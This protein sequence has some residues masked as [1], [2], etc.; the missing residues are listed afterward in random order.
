MKRFPPAEMSVALE[1]NQQKLDVIKHHII[2]SE[3]GNLPRPNIRRRW[4]ITYPELFCQTYD[5]ALCFGQKS[6]S[7]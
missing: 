2:I 1:S 3:P 6:F 7:R 5:H 4:R